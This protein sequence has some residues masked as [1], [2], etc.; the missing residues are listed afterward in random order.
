MDAAKIKGACAVICGG[1]LDDPAF[2]AAHITSDDYLIA[3]DKGCAYAAAAGLTPD[4]AV[5]DFDSLDAAPPQGVEVLT[6]PTHK[7]YTDT[8]VAL[9]EGLSR[10]YRE[11]KI[12]AAL[13][14]RLDHTCANLCLLDYLDKRGASGVLC[15]ENTRVYLVRNGSL[16]LDK[17]DGYVSIFPFGGDASGVTLNGLEYP[18]ND[19]KLKSDMPIGVS[20]RQI[21]DRA[22]IRV[23]NG[24]LLVMQVREKG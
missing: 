9:M 10:G 1:E 11:F 12:F 16:T 14:G 8:H 5:G 3:A 6:L 4:L 21:A 20:N 15:A 22:E 23:K 2:L 17:M 7:D 13:G 18:L 19:V 24:A